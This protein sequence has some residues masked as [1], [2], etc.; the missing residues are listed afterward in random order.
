MTKSQMKSEISKTFGFAY[1]EIKV[2]AWDGGYQFI[3][4][5]KGSRY[6]GDTKAKTFSNM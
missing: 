1:D 3:F 5:V 4:T 2:D 6:Q